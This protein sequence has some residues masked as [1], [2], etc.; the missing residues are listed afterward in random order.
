[1]KELEIEVLIAV[2]DL[3]NWGMGMGIG[4]G[5][6]SAADG[7]F[8]VP[9]GFPPTAV[10]KLIE[11]AEHGAI[12]ASPGLHTIYYERR[13]AQPGV[14]GQIGVGSVDR[15]EDR[16]RYRLEYL[17]ALLNS[18]A[19]DLKIE[20]QRSQS[21]FWQ[22]PKEYQRR[23]AEIRQQTHERYQQLIKRLFENNLLSDSEANSLAPTLV[24][25]VNDLRTNSSVPLPE[26]HGVVT[27]TESRRERLNLSPI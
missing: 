3:K 15:H 17:A 14:S 27:V 10:Y 11:N 19:Q 12:V 25:K 2:Y 21:I 24:I 5:G 22:G 26:I 1:M 6:I 23:V 4:S 9:D 20:P 13:V 7:I 18:K 16:D 8:G